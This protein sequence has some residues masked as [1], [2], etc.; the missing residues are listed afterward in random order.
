MIRVSSAAISGT[1]RS[2]SRARSVTSP[3]LPMGVATTY[4]VP[5][6]RR[7]RRRRAASATAAPRHGRPLARRRAR[8]APRVQVVDARGPRPELRD[9]RHLALE[10]GARDHPVDALHH[11]PVEAQRHDLVDRAPLVD[12]P[13]QEPV[14]LRV[15]RSPTS[16]SSVWPGHRSA[17]GA[18]RMIASGTP[19]AADS[20]RTWLLYR[21]PMGLNAQAESPNSVVYP[22]SDSVLLPGPHHEAAPGHR[23]VVEHRHP[24]PGHEVAAPQRRRLERL[25]PPSPG[26]PSA[27]E[28]PVHHRR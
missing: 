2:T 12:P 10:L 4:S 11:R 28:V 15:A 24:H 3:R 21:S 26:T 6:G 16:V 8:P 27:P 9:R 23:A 14:Q 20:C 7:R 18:L 5:P 17:D 13:E 1:A 19:I 22:I 25:G